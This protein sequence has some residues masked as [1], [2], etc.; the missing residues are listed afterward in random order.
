MD[1]SLLTTDAAFAAFTQALRETISDDKY[2]EAQFV[3]KMTD[4]AIAG[5]QATAEEREQCITGIMTNLFLQ[6]GTLIEI[7]GLATRSDLNGMMAVVQ[8]SLK[9]GRLP[10]KVSLSDEHVKLRP[11][12][13]R[14]AAAT[15]SPFPGSFEPG[16]LVELFG[17]T[18]TSAA[19]L[20]GCIG[21]V[22]AE[23]D[24][25]GHERI[26]VRLN[27]AGESKCIRIKPTNL[28]AASAERALADGVLALS[29]G[30][31]RDALAR[32]DRTLEV[33]PTSRPANVLRVRAMVD[34]GKREPRICQAVALADAV[35]FMVQRCGL[36]AVPSDVCVLSS[37][38]GREGVGGDDQGWPRERATTYT[39]A[40]AALALAKEVRAAHGGGKHPLRI[41]LLGCRWD[42][43][44]RVDWRLL[45]R[46]LRRLLFHEGAEDGGSG[47]DGTTALGTSTQC[48]RQRLQSLHVSLIGPELGDQTG[49]APVDRAEASREMKRA[50]EASGSGLFFQVRECTYHDAFARE[51]RQPNPAAEDG[52]TDGIMLE[53]I[54]D[55][56]GLL[57]PHLAV[58]LN[59]GV[60][61][62]FGT[63]G[64]SLA[65][66]L[67]DNVPTA[68]TGYGNT[69]NGQ[70]TY[71]IGTLPVLESMRAQTVCS[72]APNPFR[73]AQQ[74]L[75]TVCCDA[76][77]VGV[78]GCGTQSP[79]DDEEIPN[80]H[81][82]ERI[83]KLESLAALN[84]RDGYVPATGLLRELRADVESG[85]VVI[86]PS[87]T[88][89]D[90]EKWAQGRGPRKW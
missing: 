21:E 59:G 11:R 26:A 81:A 66:L 46:L 38:A 57:R 88:H 13:M 5:G 47:E 55:S 40:L 80:I 52:R 73:F 44:G 3:L 48:P 12:N 67:R 17:L 78:C 33:A 18:S 58:I 28:A 72:L 75:R 36:A 41:A 34:A 23:I 76:F 15:A 85:K 54:T 86:P 30:R 39:I 8:G 37:S 27:V 45:L 16:T 74:F 7:I 19:G 29:Q 62:Y 31:P 22:L 4:N 53:D 70:P 14:P 1:P 64:Y 69:T 49:Y 61:N 9:D 65:R 50:V 68:L 63:W 56:T 10:V 24:G 84:D 89:G 90:L 77:L 35:L 51:G 42:V 83:A 82:R 32:A 71:D 25:A 79:P 87:V 6:S 43:E 20:N 2:E 60:D